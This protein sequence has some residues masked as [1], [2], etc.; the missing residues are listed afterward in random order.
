[1]RTNPARLFAVLAAT[2]LAAG[3]LEPQTARADFRPPA[4]PLVTYN[5]F[6]SIW[7]GA[8]HLNDANTKHWTGR[9]HALVSLIRIDGKTYRLMGAEPKPLPAFT[10][11]SVEVLPTRSIY[12][13]EEA[14][15]H[16]TMTFMQP[17]LP[18][19]LDVYSWPL[20]YITWN[21]RSA[22]GARHQI[23]LYDSTSSQL[24][25]NQTDEPVEWSRQTAGDLTLLRVGTQ[26][27][28][29]LGSCGDDHRIN[30]GY[31]LRRRGGRASRKR[32]S[33]RTG[34]WKRPSST[35]AGCPRPTTRACHERPMTPSPCW[36]SS[37]IWAGRRRK[38]SSGRSSWP[39]TKSS[40]SSTSARN[41]R[42]T[43]RGTA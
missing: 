34:R 18:D 22:D 31:A 4:V 28:P 5:P 14:G 27:Q 9:T 39:T 13:F 30:W 7:S 37:S 6:L 41:C 43:G 19:D 29:V 17:A 25:V 36:P 40:P 21:V 38:P 42:P 32:R 10:Q 11:K 15:V 8:D 3:L 26:A 35:A 1:M 23:E 33:A 2:L 12:E 20:S 16:V 24:A